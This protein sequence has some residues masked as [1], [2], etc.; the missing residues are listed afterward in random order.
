MNAAHPTSAAPAIPSR[1][2]ALALLALP[3]LLAACQGQPHQPDAASDPLAAA[4]ADTA[5]ALAAQAGRQAVR[6]QDG[7][8]AARAIMARVLD[9]GE[10]R[11]TTRNADAQVETTGVPKKLGPVQPRGTQ[12]LAQAQAARDRFLQVTAGGYIGGPVD[13]RLNFAQWAY[14]FAQTRTA[15]DGRTSRRLQFFDAQGQEIH[16]VTL[17]QDDGMARFEQ[18]VADFRATGEAASPTRLALQSAPAEP[19]D[20]PDAQIDVA[21]YH[22]AWRGITDVHQFHGIQKTFRLGREQAMRLAP[23]GATRRLPPQALGSLVDG[24]V[25]QQ[26]PIMAFVGNTGLTQVYSGTLQAA[27]TRGTWLAATGPGVRLLLRQQAA[28]SGW[29]ATRGGVTSVDFFD[30]EGRTIVTFFGER[31]GADHRIAPAWPA[32]VETL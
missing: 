7:P 27:H 5:Q 19:P 23:A 3:P 15:S 31:L 16:Q 26:V 32:L 25:R 11:A 14:A 20:L 2:Q 9:L 22:E 6:L 8:D 12:T 18:L 30:R 10:I 21:G 28:A 17:T 4:P 29:V 24:A 13:L 1:R